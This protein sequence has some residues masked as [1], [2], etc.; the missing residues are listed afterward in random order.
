MK[1]KI[2]VTFPRFRASWGSLKAVNSRGL[3]YRLTKH[4]PNVGRKPRLSSTVKTQQGKSDQVV[5]LQN[6]EQ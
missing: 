6:D 5:S 4:G 2:Q 1:C 3:P